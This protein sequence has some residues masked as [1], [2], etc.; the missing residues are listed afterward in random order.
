M[1]ELKVRGGA[2]ALAGEVT[3]PGDKSIGHRALLF[4]ALCAPGREIPIFGLS[5]GE[6]NLRT[7]QALSQLGVTF[8]A[9]ADALHVRGVGLS[10]LRE[11][12]APLDCGNS[13][14][15]IRLLSGLLAGRP[16][17]SRLT[18][19]EYLRARPMMRI[20]EPLRKMG[21]RVEGADGKKE[22]EIYPP[23]EI[24]PATR[25][26]VGIEYR[27][28]V[29][30]A[31]V[32]SAVLLAALQADGPTTFFEPELSRDHTE[33]MLS[34]MGVDL[35]RLSLDP[36]GQVGVRIDPANFSG[37]LDATELR[38]PGDLSSAAF[39][40]AAGAMI[41]ESAITVRGV[42]LNPTRT[43][44]LDILRAMGG[45]LVVAGQRD[46]SGEPVGDLI[47]RASRLR[48]TTIFGALTIRAIDE[49]P[50]LAAV[51]AVAQ[52][53]TEIRDAAELRVKESDRISST[54]SF[55]RAFGVSVEER[56]DGL[57]IEGGGLLHAGVVESHGDHRIAMAGTIL[58]LAAPGE[59]LI[60]DTDNIATSFPEFAKTLRALG[61]TIA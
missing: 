17:R 8:R 35:E 9:S 54:A 1:S 11:S 33:R 16:I 37:A 60:R 46:Q 43:G 34:A 29:A 51:A 27:S 3:L 38:V 14:T 41:P 12:A 20:A 18:G 22:H 4:A 61:A 30:S 21:A 26:L 23:L 28:K 42:G 45:D 48:G 56:P 40:L 32:K 59:S 24:G 44:V 25:P 57:L 31:Q 36:S 10:G 5:A 39:V 7:R 15:S 52:G 19:D 58:A 49:L 50:L 2:R 6:D 53:T 47:A 13:G 55:L